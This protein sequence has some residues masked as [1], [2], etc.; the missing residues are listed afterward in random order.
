MSNLKRG[1]RLLMW[2]ISGAF[3]DIGVMLPIAIVLIGKNRFNPTALF[4]TAGLFYILSAYYFK[5][6]MPVQPLKAMSAIAI[7]TGLGP[8]VI[9]AASIVIGII[10]LIIAA[11]GFGERLGKLFPVPVIRGIQLGLGLMLIKSSLGLLRMDYATAAAAGAILI[12]SVYVVRKIPPLIPIVTLGII[13]SFINGRVTSLGPLALNPALPDAHAL[14]VGFTALVLPQIALSF[15]NAIVATEATGRMLYAERARRL[16]L[17]SIPTSM[18]IAN[19]ATAI[20]GG[21][22]MCHGSGGLTAHFK[23]GATRETSGYIMGLALIAVALIF[24]KSGLAVLSAFPPG[25]LGVLLCY[26]GIHHALLV[27]EI[28]QDKPALAVAY[29]VAAIGLF[30]NNLTVGLSQALEYSIA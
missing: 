26:V 25:I 17:R 5:V 23:F 2:D 29:S 27:K 20:I 21:V 1:S 15:G 14:W 24:G 11:T 12:M 10:F 22:P 7:A 13:L 19:I 4:L 18:G 8:D 16:N 9:N 6:T 30:T 3:G 28:R